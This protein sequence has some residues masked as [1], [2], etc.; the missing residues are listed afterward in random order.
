LAS[1]VCSSPAA[2][3]TDGLATSAAFEA[4]STAFSAGDYRRALELF[5]TARREGVQGPAVHYNIGVCQYKL[6]DYSAA[7]TTFRALAARFPG[8]GDL[9]EYNR[10]LALLG[11]RR[12]A[13]A[14]AAFL[15]ATSSA[16]EKIAALARAALAALASAPSATRA[17][18]LGFAAASLGY[19]D[20]VALRDELNLPPGRSSS[21][22]FVEAFGFA[23]RRFDGSVPLR[24]DASAYSVRYSDAGEF[25]QLG[26]RFGLSANWRI[27]KWTLA[28]GPT[29]ARST[30]DGDSF[31]RRVGADLRAI[32]ALNERLHV[33][34]RFIYDDIESALPRYAFIAGSRRQ[35][36]LGLEHRGAVTRFS[37]LYDDERNDRAD[38]GVSSERRRVSLGVQRRLNARWF[39]DGAVSYRVSRYH[40]LTEPRTENLTELRAALHKDLARRW[41]LNLEYQ[42]FR[43]DASATEFGYRGQR[44]TAGVSRS[45]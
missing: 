14:R 8:L 5:E 3:A 7:E 17:S 27:G 36:R 38:A 41:S 30:L 29:Y 32:R 34:A 42:R 24:F 19:D 12:G 18:W 33:E 16:D 13:D 15:R 2:F 25:D 31:E 22:P 37:V 43:N 10:G 35:S 21:S 44:L 28:A 4:G 26:L 1:L 45:Y 20:N 9:A 39:V 40:E 6:A 23:G 11:A